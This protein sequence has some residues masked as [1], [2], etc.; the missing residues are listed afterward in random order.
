MSIVG[1]RPTSFGPEV[2]N[3]WQKQRLS[4]QPGLTGLWQI[5]GRGST[6]FDERVR[7]DLAYIDRQRF[8]LDLMII[9]R[10]FRAVLGK[11]GTH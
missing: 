8:S 11:N 1:P 7:I 10:T 6:D 4:V 5:T 2:Y 3:E 9:L